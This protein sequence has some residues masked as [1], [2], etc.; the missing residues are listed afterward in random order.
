MSM[1]NWWDVIV[2]AYEPYFCCC[3]LCAKTDP[4][5]GH[6]SRCRCTN[7]C[8][9]FSIQ[10]FSL[11]FFFSPQG[12]CTINFIGFPHI[13]IVYF[14][15]TTVCSIRGFMYQPKYLFMSNFVWEIFKLTPTLLRSFA[16]RSIYLKRSALYRPLR[17]SAFRIMNICLELNLSY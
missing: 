5:R 4:C 3:F 2:S 13:H 8:A 10:F 12:C 7:M 11:F 17:R 14:L 16:I 15:K 6:C 9:C 1:S